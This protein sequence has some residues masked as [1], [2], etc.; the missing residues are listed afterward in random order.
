MKLLHCE[1]TVRESSLG[2][3]DR[4]TPGLE[5]YRPARGTGGVRAAILAAYAEAE[6]AAAASV[7]GGRARRALRG[8]PRCSFCDPS[9]TACCG[10]VSIRRKEGIARS[11]RR[12]RARFRAAIRKG[13]G[14]RRTHRNAR[15]TGFRAV[16]LVPFRDAPVGGRL[17]QRHDPI[18]RGSAASA[19]ESKREVRYAAPEPNRAV[20]STSVDAAVRGTCA[21]APQHFLNFRPLP[22]E[23]GSFLPTSLIAFTPR[24]I[25]GSRRQPQRIYDKAMFQ[26]RT[27]STGSGGPMA[28]SLLVRQLDSILCRV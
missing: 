9:A 21:G 1:R 24:V 7:S 10:G 12:A 20:E 15:E 13:A 14:D 4:A 3:A 5:P 22:H 27:L 17:R 8:V 28:T 6:E 19:N 2:T 23:H 26:E 25:T 11:D 18:V 16:D